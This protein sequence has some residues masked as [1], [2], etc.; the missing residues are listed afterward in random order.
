MDSKGRWA[1]RILLAHSFYR[2]PGG[3][4]RYV[5][6]LAKLLSRDHSVELLSSRNERLSD[7]VATAAKM[8]YS[9]RKKYEVSRVL[10]RFGPDIV[11]VHNVYPSLG[12]AVHLAS[13]DAGIPLIMTVHNFRM[14]CPNGVMFTE[15]S[16]CRR[17]QRG[18]YL[19]A[20]THDCFPSSKQSVAYAGALWSHRFVTRLEDKVSLFVCPSEFVRDELVQW[21]IHPSRVVV[22]PNF[23]YPQP[24]ANPIPGHFGVFVGRLSGEKGVGD[25]LEAL[26]IARDPPFRVVGD[27]PLATTLRG[28][29]A[30]IGLNKTEFLG[31]LPR[32]RVDEVLRR[33]RFLVIP[34]LWD[35]NAPLAGLEA[36]AHGRPLLVTS[37]GGLPELVR[38]ETGLVC[39]P[40]DP[41]LMAEQ[42][43]R[44]MEDDTYCLAAG[45][46]GLRV[47]R[48]EFGPE[49]HLARL[50][51]AYQTSIERGATAR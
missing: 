31:Q 15:G 12:P 4:D 17:C 30:K 51:A 40:G 25:L 44:L 47:S 48:G 26:R 33:A 16:P 20:V 21:G 50:E 37:R 29:A 22:T 14:R 38:E 9:G 49:M 13:A 10:D 8:F 35:E 39:P 1:L 27:G 34:S 36:M 3:E 42:I 46:R 18:N 2:I 5:R 43:V 45:T 6:E 24:D 41:R 28:E 32:D 7:T 23:V 11:H 19:N